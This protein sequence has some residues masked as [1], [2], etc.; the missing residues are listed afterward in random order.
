MKTKTKTETEKDYY[1]TISILSKAALTD[2]FIYTSKR[3]INPSSPIQIQGRRNNLRRLS[4]APASIPAASTL[5]QS[6][7]LK[8]NLGSGKL[9]G[10][11]ARLNTVPE[12]SSSSSMP[13]VPRLLPKTR[14]TSLGRSFGSGPNLLVE[15][16]IKLSEIACLVV[17]K[18]CLIGSSLFVGFG[19]FGVRD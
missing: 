11:G 14:E 3:Q 7:G 2:T 17:A 12:N 8:L 18:S 10:G 1:N 13:T 6:F 9:L 5:Q 16:M 15:A 4:V 19:F